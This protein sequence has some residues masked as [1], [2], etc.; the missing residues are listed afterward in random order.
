MASGAA[1]LPK[2]LPLSTRIRLL[3]M[4]WARPYLLSLTKV[5]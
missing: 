1:C 5:G 3:K 4:L 2:G